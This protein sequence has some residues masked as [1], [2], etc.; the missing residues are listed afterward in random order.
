MNQNEELQSEFGE[1]YPDDLIN[2]VANE[3]EVGEGPCGDEN[4]GLDLDG[5]EPETSSMSA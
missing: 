5:P 3:M 4:L 1:K 2:D